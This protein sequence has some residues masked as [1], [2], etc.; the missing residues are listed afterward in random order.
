VSARVFRT[1]T[2]A[3]FRLSVGRDLGATQLH[4]ITGDV[5]RLGPHRGMSCGRTYL[6]P[7]GPLAAHAQFRHPLQAGSSVG[8]SVDREAG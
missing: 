5:T 4:V 6:P 8:F 2:D 1:V 7:Y 3:E